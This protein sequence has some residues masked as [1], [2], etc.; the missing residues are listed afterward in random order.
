VTCVEGLE[1][2]EDDVEGA[3]V[4]VPCPPLSAAGR[5]ERKASVRPSGDQRGEVEDCGLVVNCRG[6]R[7]ASAA[8]NQICDSRRFC[9][10]STVVTT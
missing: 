10:W 8:V 2:G 7:L 9:F 3:T 5:D 6:A 4:I 1:D